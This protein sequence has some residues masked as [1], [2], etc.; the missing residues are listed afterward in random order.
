VEFRVARPLGTPPVPERPHF[1]SFDPALTASAERAVEAQFLLHAADACLGEP[2]RVEETP[3]GVRVRSNNGS[4][5]RWPEALSSSARLA[6][7]LGALAELRGHIRGG[8]VPKN[9]AI[10]KEALA[11]AQALRALGQEFS[12][13]LTAALP[14]RSRHLLQLMLQNHIEGV[15][16]S[17]GDLPLDAAGA[18][19]PE[20]I[21]WRDAADRLYQAL[22][23]AGEDA[24]PPQRIGRL[25]QALSDGFAAESRQAVEHADVEQGIRK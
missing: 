6:D 2:V 9:P 11:H 20:P 13:R 12:V 5:G 16:A 3:G 15:R 7:V 4:A 22:A 21:D 23:N 10:P 24:L 14:E 25:L 1:F 17:I 18:S 19:A 8:Q